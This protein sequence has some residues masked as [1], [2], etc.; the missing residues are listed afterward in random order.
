MQR[1][2]KIPVAEVKASAVDVGTGRTSCLVLLHKRRVSAAA[3]RGE[4]PVGVCRLC[5]DCHQ[6]FCSKK[7]R[8]CKFSLANDLW[9]G[10]IDCCGMQT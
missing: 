3:A 2:P 8:L 5:R 9:L 6:S 1:W 4:E 7:P 10:R